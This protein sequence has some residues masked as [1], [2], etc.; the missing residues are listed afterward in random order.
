ML[1][2]AC[3]ISVI[4]EC[5]EH[6]KGCR[7]RGAVRGFKNSLAQEGL[8]GIDAV[9]AICIHATYHDVVSA[10]TGSETGYVGGIKELTGKKLSRLGVTRNTNQIRKSTSNGREREKR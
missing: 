5:H 4:R 9:Q 3:R 2:A 10:S 6:A 7:H 1:R 8:D